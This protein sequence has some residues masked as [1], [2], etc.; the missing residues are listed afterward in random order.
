MIPMFRRTE[1]KRAKLCKRSAYGP[2]K[3]I[4]VKFATRNIGIYRDAA[5]VLS[6][7]LREI[8]IDSEL[9]VIETANV[10]LIPPSQ[11]GQYVV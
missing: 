6:D 8:Y 4:N 7:Q 10:W 11:V 3:R 9:D 1:Q 2:D 5:V